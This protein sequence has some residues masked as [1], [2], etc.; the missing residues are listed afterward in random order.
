[1][2]CHL[3]EPECFRE[4]KLSST[5]LFE[6]LQCSIG[7]V[8][9]R[10]QHHAGKR[11]RELILLWSSVPAFKDLDECTFEEGVKRTVLKLQKQDLQQNG[12]IRV[13]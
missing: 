13:V 1:M 2:A 12:T 9:K 4:E 8:V 10:A 6:K 11:D 5:D 7:I 3:G